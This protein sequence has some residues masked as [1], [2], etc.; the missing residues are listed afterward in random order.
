MHLYWWNSVHNLC[1]AFLLDPNWELY[2]FLPLIV[3]SM[4]GNSFSFQCLSCVKYAIVLRLMSAIPFRPILLFLLPKTNCGAVIAGHRLLI[5][6]SSIFWDCE[7]ELWLVTHAHVTDNNYQ[8]KTL[9]LS[10]SPP[11]KCEMY[12][13]WEQPHEKRIT[14]LAPRMKTKITKKNPRNMKKLIIF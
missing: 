1:L 12:S 7:R 4:L 8:I 10:V 14:I 6:L 11:F 9:K 2:L 13:I 3:S 5:A